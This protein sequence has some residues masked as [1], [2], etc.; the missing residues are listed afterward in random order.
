MRG[1]SGVCVTLGVVRLMAR[2]DPLGRLTDEG[3]R[4]VVACAGILESW[5]QMPA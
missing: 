5:G 3:P 4:S 2:R 1:G